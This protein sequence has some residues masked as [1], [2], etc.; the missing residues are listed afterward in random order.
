MKRNNPSVDYV[1]S[2]LYTRE[3]IYLY[4]CE[5]FHKGAY[6]NLSLPC[7]RGGVSVG[8]T[9]GLSLPKCTHH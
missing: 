2:S 7:V 5:P 4:K 8:E 3:P 6:I 9:E 1:D